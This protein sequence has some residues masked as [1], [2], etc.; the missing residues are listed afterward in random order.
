MLLGVL[1]GLI[2]GELTLHI[3]YAGKVHIKHV[4][5]LHKLSFRPTLGLRRGN[6]RPQ[7]LLHVESELVQGDLSPV[8]VT[9]NHF[10]SDCNLKKGLLEVF[11]IELVTIL[12]LGPVGSLLGSRKSGG[13]LLG[14]HLQVARKFKFY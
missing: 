9:H 13:F 12:F 6:T 10:V 4:P 1:L 11:H 2:S 8:D 3:L 5:G 7:V 14:R